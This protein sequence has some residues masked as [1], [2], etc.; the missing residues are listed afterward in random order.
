[1]G[2]FANEFGSLS[3]NGVDVY[4][5]TYDSQQNMSA[6]GN[7]CGLSTMLNPITVVYNATDLSPITQTI[8]FKTNLAKLNVDSAMMLRNI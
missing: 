5:I 7:L 6:Y 2:T 4:N 3:L 1:M 8:I